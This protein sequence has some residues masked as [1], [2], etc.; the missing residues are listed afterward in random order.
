MLLAPDLRS[1]VADGYLADKGMIPMPDS[2]RSKFHNDA[3]MMKP[4][5]ADDLK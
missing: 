3:T 2:E 5:S 4:L 1:L